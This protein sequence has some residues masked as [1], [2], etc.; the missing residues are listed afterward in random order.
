MHFYPTVCIHSGFAPRS[1]TRHSCF[2]CQ[3]LLL[4]FCV[5][6]E[7]LGSAN[8]FW[9]KLCHESAFSSSL[10]S[11]KDILTD[12]DLIDRATNVNLGSNK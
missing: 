10:P 7:L 3:F 6:N 11:S 4:S 5:L 1:L 2:K 9:Y 8:V 12:I